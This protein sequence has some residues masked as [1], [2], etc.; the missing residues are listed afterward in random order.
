MV[1]RACGGQCLNGCVLCEQTLNGKNLENRTKPYSANSSNRSPPAGGQA[2]RSRRAESQ[3]KGF[4]WASLHVR[5][6][7]ATRTAATTPVVRTMGS[8]DC[9]SREKATVARCNRLLRAF[10]TLL[11]AT[12]LSTSHLAWSKPRRVRDAPIVDHPTTS[13]TNGPTAQYHDAVAALIG[14]RGPMCTGVLVH[15][16]AILTAKHCLAARA[17]AFGP[18]AQAPLLVRR[19]VGQLTPPNRAVDLALVLIESVALQPVRFREKHEPYTLRVRVVGFGATNWTR[20]DD[21][22]ERTYFDVKFVGADCDHALAAD[23][24]CLPGLE[25]VLPRTAGIDTCSGDSG[26][27]ILEVQSGAWRVVAVTSRSVSNALLPCGDGG[28]YV[29]TDAVAVWLTAQ[30]KELDNDRKETIKG[31]K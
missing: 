19:I 30:L 20:P 21:I 2:Q 8:M 22:D 9:G 18:S 6:M 27:P 14:V 11:S 16:R 24:G 10:G 28:I 25:L 23:T 29:R 4:A 7:S 5:T 31:G 15:S 26:G 13:T 1:G 17:V 3:S 12:L